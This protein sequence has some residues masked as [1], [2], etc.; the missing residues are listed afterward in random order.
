MPPTLPSLSPVL[1]TGGCGLIG[2]HLVQY[3]LD[4]DPSGQIHVLDINISRNRFP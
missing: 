1:I 3:L 2:R 4:A